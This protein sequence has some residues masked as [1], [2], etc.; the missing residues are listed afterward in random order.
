MP[1]IHFD[2]RL[3]ELEAKTLLAGLNS[4]PGFTRMTRNDLMGE[5]NTRVVLREDGNVV[6]IG[7]SSGIT[8]GWIELHVLFVIPE[9][10]SQGYGRMIW[11]KIHDL[12]PASSVLLVTNNNKVKTMTK[13]TYTVTSVLQLPPRI[14]WYVI[15]TRSRPSKLFALIKQLVHKDVTLGN[16][17][18]YTKSK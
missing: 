7:I 6:G 11:N 14:I 2:T 15:A 9:K 5:K 12:Y 18:Y 16:F 17:T 13:D 1:N 4:S 8:E 3:S 10:R